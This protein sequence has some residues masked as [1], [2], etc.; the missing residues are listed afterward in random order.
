MRPLS[1]VGSSPRGRGKHCR[2]W[3]TCGGFRLIPARAG[4]TRP[5]RAGRADHA[6]HPRAG[7]ENSRRPHSRTM[8]LGSSPRGRGKPSSATVIHERVRLIP[9]RAGKTGWWGLPGVGQRFAGSSPRGRGKP[10]HELRLDRAVRLI[11][12][13]AGKTVCSAASTVRCAAHP[14]AGGENP[15][16]GAFPARSEGSSPRGRGKLV[17]EEQGVD[18]EGLIP[19]RAGKTSRNFLTSPPISAHPRAGGENLDPSGAVNLI[20]G[21]SPRGRGKLLSHDCFIPATGLIPA[22]AG[23]TGSS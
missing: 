17:G 15:V 20:V 21:S 13:R 19:A 3:R 9:A 1:S 16:G 23:K 7:G 14:R 22:R 5:R 11:P 12:A 8:F 10:M 18:I 4:K 2:R 6:A